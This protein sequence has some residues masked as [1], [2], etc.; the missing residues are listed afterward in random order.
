ML[1]EYHMVVLTVCKSLLK[2]INARKPAITAKGA[3]L[4]TAKSFPKRSPENI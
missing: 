4:I 1:Y 3:R 2:S